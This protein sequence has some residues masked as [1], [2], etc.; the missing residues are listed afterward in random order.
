MFLVDVPVIFYKLGGIMSNIDIIAK[1]RLDKTKS[2]Q[3]YKF[4]FKNIK[5]SP[6]KFVKIYE[7]N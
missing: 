2:W 3:L 7:K 1:K 4:Q 5:N 6:I